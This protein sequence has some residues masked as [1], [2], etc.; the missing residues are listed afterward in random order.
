MIFERKNKNVKKKWTD[1]GFEFENI[2]INKRRRKNVIN[3]SLN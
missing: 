1:W 3:Y 2:I